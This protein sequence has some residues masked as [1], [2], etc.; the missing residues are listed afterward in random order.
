MDLKKLEE[1]FTGITNAISGTLMYT[2]LLVQVPT[3]VYLFIASLAVHYS[4]AHFVL[5][6]IAML[7]N[8][9]LFGHTVLR[10]FPWLRRLY[11]KCKRKTCKSFHFVA[12]CSFNEFF[13]RYNGTP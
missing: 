13:Y 3:L 5:A 1:A 11:F 12:C 6:P 7:A 9:L 4:I 10:H 2:A 8:V